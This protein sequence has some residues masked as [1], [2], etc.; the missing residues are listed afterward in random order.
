MYSVQVTLFRLDPD[1]DEWFSTGQLPAKSYTCGHC[2]HRVA[3]AEGF[4]A[5]VR[6]STSAQQRSNALGLSNTPQLRATAHICS[7]CGLPTV[8]DRNGGSQ[9]PGPLVGADIAALPND[10]SALYSEARK[11]LAG[12]APSAAVMVC[13]KILMHVAVEKGADENKRFVEYVDYLST[14]GWVPPVSGGEVL[15]FIKNQGN[16][17]NHRIQ[18]STSENAEALIKLMERFLGWVYEVPALVATKPSEVESS[19]KQPPQAP[20]MIPL[21]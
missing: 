7:S 15:K 16:D 4:H 20:P 21:R 13:R 19:T 3:P 17:E 2:G 9:T 8:F 14:K 5:F 6:G 10:V 12:G 18:T 11:A 1:N